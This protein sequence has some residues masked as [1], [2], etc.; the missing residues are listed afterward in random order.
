MRNCT[1]IADFCNNGN[2]GTKKTPGERG[3]SHSFATGV[4]CHQ[5]VSGLCQ[6][7]LH[8]FG[9]LKYSRENEQ[10]GKRRRPRGNGAFGW[11]LR[12]ELKA[13]LANLR[14]LSLDLFLGLA[15]LLL[16]NADTFLVVAL[17]SLNVVIGQI[18]PFLSHLALELV[19]VS[20]NLFSVHF[21]SY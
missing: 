3:V 10:A 9:S 11:G 2:L 20:F 1:I 14:Q 8:N 13:V 15:V 21:S 17:H 16:Q 19:P 6:D 12:C 4:R 5:I 7:F 18:C